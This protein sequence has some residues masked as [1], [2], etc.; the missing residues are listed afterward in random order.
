MAN[1]EVFP[2]SEREAFAAACRRHGFIAADFHVLDLRAERGI[3]MISILQPETGVS[4]QYASGKGKRWP[5][6]F[7]HDLEADVFGPA[8]A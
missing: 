7:E 4:L 5:M 2:S 6:A 1:L 3:G 8:P